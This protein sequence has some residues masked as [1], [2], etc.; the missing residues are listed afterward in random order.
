[1]TTPSWLGKLDAYLI[2]WPV[3]VVAVWWLLFAASLAV[4]VSALVSPPIAEGTRLG[5]AHAD[6]VL[7]QRLWAVMAAGV[8]GVLMLISIDVRLARK[9]QRTKSNHQESLWVRGSS[10]R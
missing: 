6:H 4:V 1:M 7:T 2:L 5:W 9:E 3:A 10:A 8:A